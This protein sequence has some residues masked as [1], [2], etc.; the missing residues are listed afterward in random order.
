MRVSAAGN[1]HLAKHSERVS[2]NFLRLL[3][4]A[5]LFTPAVK[6]TCIISLGHNAE[7]LRENCMS[8][9]AFCAPSR[10]V[11]TNTQYFELFYF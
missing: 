4:I 2:R 10:G 6:T 8:P 5:A 9:L 7:I 1:F 11:M 3:R